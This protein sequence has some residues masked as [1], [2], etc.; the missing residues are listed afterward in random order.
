MFRS[1]S[2]LTR[3]H[4]PAGE[5]TTLTELRVNGNDFAVLPDDISRLVRLRKL[6]MRY[7]IRIVCD[8][9]TRK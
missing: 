6:I 7:A 2:V 8:T 4:T 5:L 3:V 9:H 1:H